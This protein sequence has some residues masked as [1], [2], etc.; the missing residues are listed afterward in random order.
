[1]F[2]PSIQWISLVV[3]VGLFMASEATAQ[4]DKPNIVRVA[5]EGAIP[6][7]RKVF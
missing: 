5:D 2:R 3:Y 1:M 4:S 7:E 6:A